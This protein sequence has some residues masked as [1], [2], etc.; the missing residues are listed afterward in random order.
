MSW[1]RKL[2]FKFNLFERIK[3]RVL[4]FPH[5]LSNYSDGIYVF[6]SEI[7]SFLFLNKLSKIKNNSNLKD[8]LDFFNTNDFLV[9]ED[10]IDKKTVAFFLNSLQ[11]LT[12]DDFCDQNDLALPKNIFY[13]QVIKNLDFL[14][15]FP[16]KVFEEYNHLRFTHDLIYRAP[17]DLFNMIISKSEYLLKS[18]VQIEVAEIYQTLANGDKEK[19]NSKW[20][21][22]GD[23]SKSFKVLIYL[24][25]VGKDDGALK[26]KSKIDQKE[27]EFFGQA[28]TAIFFKN[29]MLEHLGSIPKN[30]S[31]WCLNFKVYPKIFSSSVVTEEKPFN[32]LRRKSLFRGV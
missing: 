28:G 29:S 8:E 32:F 18:K 31:R 15:D 22:D 7:Y 24:N 13:D 26:V 25:D 4:K 3:Y 12:I 9:I 14:Y 21:H 10:F 11:K 30:N 23:I 16:K 6:L 19:V 1:I 2:I 20:H 17:E 27:I 5:K